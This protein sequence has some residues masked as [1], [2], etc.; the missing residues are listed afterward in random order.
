MRRSP[1]HAAAE[2]IGKALA[3]LEIPFAVAGALAANAHGHVRTTEDVDILLTRE[4]LEKFKAHWLGRGW[5]EKFPG[6]RGMTDTVAGVDIDVLIT[7]EYPGDGKPKPVAFPDPSGVVVPDADGIPILALAAL[8]E[9]KLA[10]G[11]SAPHRIQDL[12]DV[13]QLVRANR[14]SREFEQQL[15]PY[16]REKYREILS[17]SQFVDPLA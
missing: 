11:M 6:S 12:A 17:A 8:I 4:G 7:G 14:L 3:E 5:V 15:S 1:I 16:V 10:S 2:R 13:L 9:L